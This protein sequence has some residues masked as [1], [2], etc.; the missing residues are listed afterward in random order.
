[1]E[2][3]TLRYRGVD[4]CTTP[5]NSQGITALEMLAILE[6]AGAPELEV[7]SADYIDVF[8][9]AKRA[10]FEDRDRFVG[11]PR[12]VNVPVERL[13]SREHA[14]QR[15]RA[16]VGQ[17]TTYPSLGDTVYVAAV[18]ALGNACSLIQSI[19]Y[20]FGSAF[21][22]GDTGILMQNRGHYFSLDRGHPNELAPGQRTLHTLM[23]SMAL[24][25]G[26]P[27][28]VFGTMGADGQPQATVQVLDRILTSES[29]QS[30]V[31]APRVLSGRF[32]LEDDAER[33]L[34]EDRID[35]ETIEQLRRRG[36]DVVTSSSFDERMG[37]AHA[38][39]LTNRGL[40]VGVD[41]RSDGRVGR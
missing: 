38:I 1:V 4:V 31:A 18:D 27:W 13:L 32:L 21:V 39:L 9:H 14:E 35:P 10:A 25:D 34:A 12:H 40:E 20:A 16:L 3:I 29:P 11:D 30:A 41:P 2:P 7:G 6:H 22:A 37:H 36:H 23:A 24:R 8:V 19:Y 28:L 33:L 17:A 15:A 5:P 26:R